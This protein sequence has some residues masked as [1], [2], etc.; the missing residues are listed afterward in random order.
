MAQTLDLDHDSPDALA[1]VASGFH[2]VSSD[3]PLEFYGSVGLG[4]WTWV[5][6]F[7]ISGH[8][9]RVPGFGLSGWLS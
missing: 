1:W 9:A 5:S 8:R 3:V 2:G 6:R 7:G 4:N